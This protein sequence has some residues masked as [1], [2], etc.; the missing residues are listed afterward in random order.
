M[1]KWRDEFGYAAYPFD[2]DLEDNKAIIE[3]YP[4]LLKDLTGEVN[5][6]VKECL[7]Q[8]IRVGTDAYDACICALLA[9]LYGAQGRFK[10]F[11]P[12]VAPPHQ[13][14]TVKSEGWIYY[15]PR[16]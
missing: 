8:G 15:L 13:M 2:D 12:L 6:T 4:A 9:V 5:S 14:L 1:Q 3:V 11:S 16:V 10:N 7:P